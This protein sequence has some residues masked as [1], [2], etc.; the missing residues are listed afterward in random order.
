MGSPGRGR[1]APPPS[2]VCPPI[3]F[4]PAGPDRL[5]RGLRLRQFYAGGL[6]GGEAPVTYVTDD[7]GLADVA[8][9]EHSLQLSHVANWLGVQ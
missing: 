8:F 1:R 9:T 3:T 6:A 5:G 2:R 4:V 7:D